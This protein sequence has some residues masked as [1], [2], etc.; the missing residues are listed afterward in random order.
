[1]S[2]A[3]SSPQG[4]EASQALSIDGLFSDGSIS[5]LWAE[6]LMALLCQSTARVARMRSP[7][8]LHLDGEPTFSV[9]RRKTRAGM[10]P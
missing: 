6:R 3:I 2:E 7:R 1:M 8:A 10:L 9:H 5:E 4:P